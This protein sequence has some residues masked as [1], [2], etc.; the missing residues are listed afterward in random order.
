[1][2]AT[3]SQEHS[4]YVIPSCSVVR[5]VRLEVAAARAIID[6]IERSVS[7][8]RPRLESSL[9]VHLLEQLRALARVLGG[10]SGPEA[11]AERGPRADLRSGW[12]GGHVRIALAWPAQR[13]VEDLVRTFR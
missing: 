12:D 9:E 10:C 6:E 2:P 11:A 8:A 1:M 13:E 7:G 5:R 3:T 4:G